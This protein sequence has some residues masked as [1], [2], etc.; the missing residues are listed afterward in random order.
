MRIS[1]QTKELSVKIG[2]H[3]TGLAGKTTSVLYIYD[4]NSALKEKEFRSTYCDMYGHQLFCSTILK[5]EY[6]GWKIK[7]SLVAKVGAIYL[8]EG[9]YKALESVDGII[10]V[11]DSQPDRMEA[12]L[13]YLYFL[14]DIFQRFGYNWEQMPYALQLK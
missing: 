2:Y 13:N 9:N 5:E 8:N 1:N 10:F 3:G 14:D 4:L 11:A 6:K 12:N 7:L